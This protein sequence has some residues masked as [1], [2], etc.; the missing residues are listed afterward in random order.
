ME[1]ERDTRSYC[2]AGG[3][4]YHGGQILLL[5]RPGRNEIRLP[6]GHIE[7]GES[8]AETALREVQE[9]SGYAQLTIVRDLG[10]TTV[11]FDNP[12]DGLHYRRREH[13]FLMVLASD[14]RQ[15]RPAPDAQFSPF[16]VASE[17]ALDLLTFESERDVVRRARDFLSAPPCE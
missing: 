8:A 10:T 15:P 11:E 2:A 4:V 13:Y 17:E 12:Q 9:E 14:R 16:W 7:A 6:K 3:V 1:T 5:N